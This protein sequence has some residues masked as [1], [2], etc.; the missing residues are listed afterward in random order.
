MM[1]NLFVSFYSAITDN[2]TFFI[3]LLFKFVDKISLSISS[4]SLSDRSS[5]D[6]YHTDISTCLDKKFHLI[7][8]VII[9]STRSGFDAKRYIAN[10]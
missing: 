9:V 10:S 3:S 2:L 8:E 4:I 1:S 5:M 7:F 6:A